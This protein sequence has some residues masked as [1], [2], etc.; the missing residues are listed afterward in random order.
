[1]H[2]SNIFCSNNE[3]DTVVFAH[4]AKCIDIADKQCC[5]NNADSN[6]KDQNIESNFSG[7]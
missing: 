7:M 5:T 1:M 3:H 6:M 4:H 2:I